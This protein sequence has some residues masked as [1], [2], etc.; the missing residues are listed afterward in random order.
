MDFYFYDYLYWILFFVPLLFLVYKFS[1]VERKS[2]WKHLAFGMR[3][4]GIILI[5][6]AV[7][8]PLMNRW[9]SQCH[10]IF[11]L[12]V[13]ESVDLKTSLKGLKNIRNKI[14]QLRGGDSFQLFLFGSKLLEINPQAA[15]KKLNKWITN[16][17]D[18]SFR[19]QTKV[20]ESINST[21][22]FFPENKSK[23]IILY[24]DG[25]ETGRSLN[26]LR[27]KLNQEKIDIQIYPLQNIQKPEAAV[28][29]LLASSENTFYGERVRL[30]AS[31]IANADMKATLGF[32]HR[33]IKE[34]EV[35]LDLKAQKETLVECDVIMTSNGKNVWTVELQSQ[36]DYF[37]INNKASC[38]IEVKGKPKILVLHEKPLKMRSFKRTLTRQ[39]FEIELRGKNGLPENMNEM[40]EFDGIILANIPATV[41]KYR[42]MEHLK[43]YVQEFGGALIMIGSENSFGLG[44]YYKT[45]VE[46]VLPIV[47][48]FEKE[49][50]KPS[51]SMVLVIDKSGSMSGQPIS[52]ARQAAKSA[53]ELL[54]PR[55]RVAVVAFDSREFVACELTFASSK[56]S[57]IAAIEQ[58]G[59]GGGTNMY[60]AMLR[61][62][63]MLETTPSKI[64]H[65]IILGDGQSSAADFE[66]LASEMA[67]INITV[68]TVALGSGADQ[69]LMSS[70]A[71]IGKGRYYETMDPSSI[72]QIFTKETM[73]ASRSA[74]KEEPFIPVKVDR[75]YFL[76]GI[77]F[78]QAPY[79]LG[80]VM[81]KMK[82][83]AKMILLTQAGDPLLAI[84]NF[85]LGASVAFTSDA[86]E[87]W[88]GEWLEWSEFGKFWAQLIRYTLRKDARSEFKLKKS[89]DNYKN[90][91][92]QSMNASNIIFTL[93]A[94]EKSGSPINGLK[95]EGLMMDEHG[96][97]KKIMV[98]ESGLGLYESKVPLPS[99]GRY[100][101][102]FSNPIYNVIKTA[103]FHQDYP[104]EYRLN[105][106][107]SKGF[108]SIPKIGEKA[109]YED[110]QEV[111]LQ[112]DI[113]QYFL[114][115]GMLAIL[116]GILF[117]RLG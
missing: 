60:P 59:A 32:Y 65:V 90:K 81:T 100:T 93:K 107:P 21:R 72:P 9:I 86:T 78:E 102:R 25:I 80:Y 46:E 27:K 111:Y 20:V 11:L 50:E 92:G 84:G 30:K 49:K 103:Y 16:I 104:R 19:K 75:G 62:K 99:K 63:S 55:D 110:L 67:G 47:S 108:L 1:L 28:I 95:W 79:L 53:V 39:N 12:D 114:L 82:P 33:G 2:I 17:P 106:K 38:T 8:R 57:I 101:F 73:E 42:Q 74:I 35:T 6:L 76:E 58:I 91:S 105:S 31:V 48:R 29:S 109:P 88:A 98:T 34:K 94:N 69:A 10:I 45:P 83:T 68:S 44:G 37:P 71:K 97:R 23:R 13:S 22:M 85:G 3:L 70:I 56:D 40:L 15:E 4:L 116:I 54:G 7:C 113:F 96:S 61:A 112:Q 87:Q 117:R 43:S 77:D 26:G 14:S 115:L 52:M 41:L 89:F 66:G 51:L 24:S 64:K 18:A 36:K 5:L